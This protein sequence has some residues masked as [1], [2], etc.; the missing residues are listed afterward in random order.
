MNILFE[1]VNKRYLGEDIEKETYTFYEYVLEE[2]NR[3]KLGIRQRDIAYVDGLMKNIKLS[4]SILNKKE[5]E[6]YTDGTNAVI[7]K[8]F[9]HIVRK[10]IL[11]FINKPSRKHYF[12]L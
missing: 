2:Q 1:D 7:K 9:E 12:L 8:R 11:N 6:D 4:R 5:K 10:K 3:E